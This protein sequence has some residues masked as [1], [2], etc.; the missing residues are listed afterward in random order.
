MSCPNEEEFDRYFEGDL[1]HDAAKVFEQHVE[2]C[3]ICRSRFTEGEANERV[4]QQVRVIFPGGSPFFT[5]DDASSDTAGN[6]KPFLSGSGRYQSRLEIPE[7]YCLSNR[8]RIVKELG[9]GGD[10]T[11][12][13]LAQDIDLDVEVALK[14]I[15]AG[16]KGAMDRIGQLRQEWQYRES[17]TDFAHITKAHPPERSN[18]Q[19]VELILLRME[20]ASM[21]LRNWLNRHFEDIDL[22]RDLG[23]ELLMQTCEGVKVLHK[24][25]QVHRD[26]KPENIL[27]FETGTSM[28]AK[29]TDFG[30]SRS[31]KHLAGQ[32]PSP[33]ACRCTPEY[34]PP[35]Q[36][37]FPRSYK[38]GIRSDIYSIGVVLFEILTGDIPFRGNRSEIFDQHLH[39]PPPK[40]TGGLHNFGKIIERCMKKDPE[41]RYKDVGA[42]IS[43]LKHVRSKF[44]L[45]VDIACHACDHINSDPTLTDCERCKKPLPKEFFR[46]CTRAECKVRL[47]QKDCPSCGQPG[48]A[49]HY[50]L[51]ERM[52]RAEK[53]KDENLAE[54][55]SLSELI[56]R[57]GA[58]EHKER[59]V[60]ILVDL[61]RKRDRVVPICCQAARACSH[62]D[63]EQALSLW[64]EVL[65]IVPRHW[66]ALEEKGRL[67][68]LLIRLVENK[69]K[70]LLLA[71]EA[72]FD[73][74]ERLLVESLEL[75]PKR[76]DI[77]E[78][79]SS[80]RVRSREYEK[81]LM[82]AQE[83]LDDRMTHQARQAVDKAL[84][85]APRSQE[86]RELLKQI[87]QMEEKTNVLFDRARQELTAAKFS[88]AHDALEEIESLCTD[89]EGLSEFREQIKR[90][91]KGYGWAMYKAEVTLDSRN[92]DKAET[93]LREAI[94]VCADAELPKRFLEQVQ[95]D[96]QQTREL[97]ECVE[98]LLETGQFERIA[99]ILDQAAKLWPSGPGLRNKRQ[100]TE[101]TRHQF[102]SFYTI[103][104]EAHTQDDLDKALENAKSALSICPKSG[105]VENL[106]RKVK[107]D[108]SCAR[109]RVSEAEAL[110]RK[111][112]FELARD[113]LRE[114][115]QKWPN[116]PDLKQI[117][118]QI[119]PMAKE[120][121]AAIDVAFQCFKQEKLDQALSECQRA[122]NLCPESEAC[123]LE[124]R[125][126]AK[127]WIIE[128]RKRRRHRVLM[129]VLT[130][131]IYIA[132]GIGCG[133][134][135]LASEFLPFLGSVARGVCS[136]I[137]GIAS[138]L[139]DFL[140]EYGL[141]M[142]KASLAMA[143]V[144]AV[145]YV[146]WWLF[147]DIA[148]LFTVLWIGVLGYSLFHPSE[149]S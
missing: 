60:E 101:R 98:P 120:Y 59:A 10:K 111:A 108:R 95:R 85:V 115:H 94:M 28:V 20:P 143:I 63:I 55:I 119:D 68:K 62:G 97:L 133:I 81:A 57:E 127:Q 36:I 145:G 103:A 7:G 52:D 42:F 149:S 48:I 131:P 4:I 49:A 84:T 87:D 112:E 34:A 67:R 75:A 107:K 78:A 109:R 46:L 134:A 88:E 114:V 144:A 13:Y 80:C 86:Y 71:D 14:I 32:R 25:G 104:E 113:S 38:T 123:M 64:E 1:N 110:L 141:T 74:A 99:R 29:I 135:K 40:L 140:C 66:Q 122:L 100:A 147:S 41:D 69:D 50:L 56:L 61:R 126:K 105:A 26:I 27:L 96:K 11:V 121:H 83:A 70:A 12:V 73:T 17:I 148:N 117:W 21:S 6:D 130:M 79:L 137:Q 16:S 89:F 65:L 136:V 139:Y 5:T 116:F 2:K 132:R 53:L 51:Q 146:V 93:L 31:L 138:A 24:S 39:K 129:Y 72:R 3:S 91:E 19:G 9:R 15:Q 18:Y 125:I 102:E 128:A 47:D 124:S 35:E 30:I 90:A 54:A 45:A 82:Q 8:Y 33:V 76:R 118:S 37:S 77:R 23:V 44:S 142:L 22:R 43:E 106:I 92:L 58:A